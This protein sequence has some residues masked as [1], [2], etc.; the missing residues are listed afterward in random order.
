[1]AKVILLEDPASKE[2]KLEEMKRNQ[3]ITKACQAIAAVKGEVDKL[4]VQ[5]SAIEAAVNGGTKVADNNFIVVTEM[6]MIQLL[7]LDSIEAEGEAKV[8][9]RV[10]VRRVQNYVE[11]MDALKSRNANP[12]CGNTV[13]VTTQWETFD[14]GVGSLNAPPPS[15]STKI[16]QDW[17]SFD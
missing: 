17:E 16:T 15:A 4:S 12:L 1:M 14:S 8:Q 2:K 6:L 11:M 10:E 13:A 9:R 3:S 7:K 5:V